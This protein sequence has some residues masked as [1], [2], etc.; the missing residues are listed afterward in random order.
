[1]LLQSTILLAFLTKSASFNRTGGN[2]N[3]WKSTR[4]HSE[5]S[6]D[7]DGVANSSNTLPQL[8]NHS[9]RLN[10]GFTGNL[11]KQARIEQKITKRTVTSPG[12]TVQNTL[13]G[14]VQI[15]KDIISIVAMEFVLMKI[16]VLVLVT[17]SM[18][19]M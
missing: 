12:F 8:F 5:S 13:F 18:Q 4:I 19:K 17:V 16:V 3:N 2:I 9:N 1:M 11:L 10:V 7:L 15:T 6:I 14:A